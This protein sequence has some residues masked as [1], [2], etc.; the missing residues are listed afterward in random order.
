MAAQVV[1]IT[2][3]P[4]EYLPIKKITWAWTTDGANGAIVD[5][6]AAGTINKTTNK[7]SGELMRFVT[8]PTDGPTDNYDITIL[9]DDGNDVLMGAGANRDTTNT[10]QVLASSLGVCLDTQLR[11]NIA[12]AGNTKSGKVYLYIK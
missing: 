8:D 11:L 9:D 1:T 6:T 12:T 7:Y 2:E 5:S 10:E 3:V 4:N